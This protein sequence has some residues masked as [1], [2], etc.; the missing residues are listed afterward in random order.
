MNLSSCTRLTNAQQADSRGDRLK[1]WREVMVVDERIVKEYTE[2]SEHGLKC[3][4]IQTHA[5]RSTKQ[6]SCDS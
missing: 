6:I 2:T 3:R 5:F 4:I 1:E